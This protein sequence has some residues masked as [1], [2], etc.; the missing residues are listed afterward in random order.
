MKSIT[1]AAAVLFLS[2]SV[3]FSFPS[4]ATPSELPP[5]ARSEVLHLLSYIRQSS[6]QFC[7]NGTWYQDTNAVCGHIQLKADYFS[8]KGRIK[9][10]E[11]FIKWAASK[12]EMSG[13]PYLVKCGDGPPM[14]LSQWLSE[15]LDRYRYRESSRGS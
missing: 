8:E 13:K 4:L 2:S 3:V 6:C 9:S 15:E 1:K 10:T 7:R 14:P 12:S 11:D 5:V